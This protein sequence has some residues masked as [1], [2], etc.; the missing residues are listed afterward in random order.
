[1]EKTTL[2]RAFF[3]DLD[4]NDGTSIEIMGRST[5]DKKRGCYPENLWDAHASKAY[6]LF[7]FLLECPH[8]ST[9]SY[10]VRGAAPRFVISLRRASV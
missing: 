2:R 4:G 6:P 5:A 3:E 1:M 8:W 9:R 7:P 10:E